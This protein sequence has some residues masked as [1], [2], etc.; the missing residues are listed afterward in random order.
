MGKIIG[1]YIFPHPPL[2]I[3]EVGK[4]AEQEVKATLEA[5]IK[6]SSEI[7]ETRPSTIIVATPHAPAFEDYIYISDREVV[8]GN[9]GRFGRADVSLAFN[10]NTELLG[11]IIKYAAQAGISCGGIDTGASNEHKQFS[12]LDHGAFVPLYYVNKEYKD[13]KLVHMSSISTLSLEEYYRFG[14]C[15]RKAV[16]ESDENVVF[17]ASGDMSHRLTKD[18]PYGYSRRGKE[19]DDLVINSIRQDDI[20]RLLHVDSDLC[21]NAGECGLRS[22]IIMLG[23]LDGYDIKPEVYSYEGPFG[24]GYAIVKFEIGNKNPLRRILEKRS[25]NKKENEDPYV[26]LARKAL[27]TYVKE[28]KVLEAPEGLPDEMLKEKA[29]TF[30]S[31]KKNGQ[32]RGC[33]GTMAPVRENIANEIIYNAI[34]SGTQDPRFYPVTPDELD[35]LVYSVD[36]LLE[37]EP[38][39]SIEELDPFRY[40][41]VVRAGYRTGVLLP[42]LEGIDTPEEQVEIAL[43][44]AGIRKSDSYS[45]ERFEVVRHK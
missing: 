18:A 29:G 6:A 42:N 26:A 11:K 12:E 13:F 21:E 32:L 44:K 22:F 15:I 45:M 25:G 43:Q 28:H 1:S 9:M 35:S 27:E 38:I 36:V 41:V 19:F 39:S 33:I 34:S 16:E 37:P 20:E 30:V 5:A 8:K 40:G 10:N 24:V 4:G 23:A 14:I 7:R 2:L 31:I 17:I 3:P